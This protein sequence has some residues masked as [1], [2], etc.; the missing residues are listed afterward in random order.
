[1]GA[2]LCSTWGDELLSNLGALLC[3]T[4]VAGLNSS[5]V[6]VLNSI[7]RYRRTVPRGWTVPKGA[8]LYSTRVVVSGYLALCNPA[9]YKRI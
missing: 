2:E 4:W 3:S 8:G 1:M 7:W 6:A 5:W 9:S